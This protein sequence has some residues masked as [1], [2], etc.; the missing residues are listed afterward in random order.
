[1]WLELETKLQE[2][3]ARIGLGGARNTVTSTERI[4]LPSFD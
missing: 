3:E 1:M 4:K 2:A